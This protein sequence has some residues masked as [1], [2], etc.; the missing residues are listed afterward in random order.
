[1]GKLY[2]SVTTKN[3]TASAQNNAVHTHDAEEIDNEIRNIITNMHQYILTMGLSLAKI[4]KNGFTENDGPAKLRYLDRAIMYISAKYTKNAEYFCR[5]ICIT[6]EKPAA[7]N[8][9]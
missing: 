2:L 7:L 3:L 9:L 1:M 5:C 8:L 6:E 4:K